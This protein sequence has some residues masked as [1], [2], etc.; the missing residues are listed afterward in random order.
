MLQEQVVGGI[1]AALDIDES[2]LRIMGLDRETEGNGKG[3]E[4]VVLYLNVFPPP[5]TQGSARSSRQIV[6]E[7]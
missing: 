4:G 1:A 5:S 3:G 7:L 6:A 2:R